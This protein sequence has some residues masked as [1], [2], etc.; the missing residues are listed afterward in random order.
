MKWTE[1]LSKSALVVGVIGL[2]ACAV[3]FGVSKD[4]FFRS[5]LLGYVYWFGI[6]FG[7]LG[8]QM[9][10]ALTG[11]RWGMGIRRPM[12]A[13]AV[14]LPVLALLF[15]PLLFGLDSLYQ[16]ADPAIV[17]GDHILQHKA[18]YLNT[19]GFI[20][21]A[22][23]CFATWS[24]LAMLLYKRSLQRGLERT[25]N[26]KMRVLSGPGLLFCALTMTMA[27]VDWL[28]SLDPHWFS[29]MFGVI[30]IVGQLLSGMAFVIAV[31]LFDAKQR[32]DAMSR[33]HLQ[34]LGNL[35]LV[36]TMLW[37]YVSF[38][39]YLI[40]YAGNMAED[41]TW[42][43]DRSGGG[44][45]YMSLTLIILHF[46]VP[47]LILVSRRSKRSSSVMGVLVCAILVMRLVENY[48]VI[49]PNFHHHSITAHV[50]DLAAPI[51]VGGVWLFWF[52]KRLG[53]K[54]LAPT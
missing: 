28:M 29:T 37:A 13:A 24:G 11:G 4:Q 8:I 21:R 25:P 22:L 53:R 50:L 33:D 16:W 34:D 20:G 46:A 18:A 45:Q 31:V 5:Y 17:E 32:K 38:S 14:T 52:L 48:W 44:W 7:C 27:S 12:F 10:H 19:P 47:F 26:A 6:A 42:Y 30:V 2:V 51:G 43:A 3:G 35:L 40:I 49:A 36:F 15:V 54:E 39:Q 41:V 1:R 23:F 9:I